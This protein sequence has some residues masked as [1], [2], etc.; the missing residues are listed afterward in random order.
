MGAEMIQGI[1]S[2]VTTC[3]KGASETA[4]AVKESKDAKAEAV[5]GKDKKEPPKDAGQAYF[6]AMQKK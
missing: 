3:I 6:E 5:T 4:K 2:I 1:C